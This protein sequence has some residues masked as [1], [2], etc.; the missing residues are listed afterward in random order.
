MRDIDND[1]R[2]SLERLTNPHDGTPRTDA[3]WGDLVDRRRKR[4]NRNR[5]FA[6]LPLLLVAVLAV[7][8]FSAQG[9]DNGRSDVATGGEEPPGVA[10]CVTEFS[11]QTLRGRAFA[12]DGS[13]MKVG[14]AKDP[15]APEEDDVFNATFEVHEWFAGGSG[16]SVTVWMQRPVELGERLLVAGEPRW[17]GAPLDDAI[18]WECGFTVAHS[19]EGASEWADAFAT[20]D[21][22][23]DCDLADDSRPSARCGGVY[24]P[25][26]FGPEQDG[27]MEQARL[28]GR[29]LLEGDCL[30][31][32]QESDAARYAPLP[33]VW[34]YGTLW[35]E[36][37]AGVRLADGTFV[38]VGAEITAAGGGHDID[39]LVGLGHAESVAGRARQC[40]GDDVEV[41]AY[42]QGELDVTAAD[43]ETDENGTLD[44]AAAVE[45]ATSPAYDFE[46][47]STSGPETA[48]DLDE[49]HFLLDG[50]SVKAIRQPYDVRPPDE[51]LAADNPYEVEVLADGSELV[52]IE[53]DSFSQAILFD[54]DGFMTNLV[55][56]SQP[57]A[58]SG[59]LPATALRDIVLRV[60]DLE[61]GS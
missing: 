54:A 23:E 10:S 34:P 7:G 16:E 39:R 5:A 4:R 55:S 57:G 30:Y 13:V 11:A 6:A 19:S 14:T 29:V 27:V 47:V 8:I 42:V 3:L 59:R 32:M 15:R 43:P 52:V 17:G 37:P 60:A 51:A 53:A 36:D 45:A 2:A 56:G 9:S 48:D 33:I 41:V 12:F 38:P 25:V 35:E 46:L 21:G 58:A 50:V 18:A 20:T 22:G 28:A 1:I 31:L 49:V 26:M 24:G 40:A 61:D 44:L